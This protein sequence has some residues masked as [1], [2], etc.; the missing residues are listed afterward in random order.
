MS[1]KGHY[2]GGSTII[3]PRNS[4][5]FKE[6]STRAP[7]N[8]GV[9]KRR[10]SLTEKA[11]EAAKKPPEVGARFT[12][13]KKRKVRKSKPATN[14]PSIIKAEPSPP[15]KGKAVIH[16]NLKKGRSREVAVEFVSDRKSKR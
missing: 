2:S 1:R 16:Q 15:Q 6:G 7:L 10:L 13:N 9:P 4:S 5:W 14:K 11:F 3:T 12:P 8:E